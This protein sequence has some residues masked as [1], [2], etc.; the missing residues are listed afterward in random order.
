MRKSHSVR[1]YSRSSST[2]IPVDDLGVLR[3]DE[4]TEDTLRRQLLEKDRENDKLHSQIDMLQAQL[5]QR[6]PLEN[7][8]ELEKEYKSLEI[9]LQGTQRENERCM[10][11]MERFVSDLPESPRV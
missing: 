10:A 5:S 6:P 3:E 11:D 7:V 1:N 2:I 4:S 9:L 8:L